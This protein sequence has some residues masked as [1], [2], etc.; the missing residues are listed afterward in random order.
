MPWEKGSPSGYSYTYRRDVESLEQA[1]LEASQAEDL[2]YLEE[3]ILLLTGACEICQLATGPY[4]T[5]HKRPIKLGDPRCEFFTRRLPEDPEK[6]SRNQ[7]QRYVNEKLGIK[8]KDSVRRLVG[9]T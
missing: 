1:R 3:S 8:N 7:V 5:K 9:P 4:C 2:R 6:A